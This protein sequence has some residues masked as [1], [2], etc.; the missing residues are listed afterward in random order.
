MLEFAWIH[1][2]RYNGKL[3]SNMKRKRA[4]AAKNRELSLQYLFS[5]RQQRI[6]ETILMNYQYE[7]PGLIQHIFSEKQIVSKRE[8]TKKILDTKFSWIFKAD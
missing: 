5:L 3:K 4:T 7:N 1:W 2:N 8:F 6:I